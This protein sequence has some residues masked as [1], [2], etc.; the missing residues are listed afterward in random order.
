MILKFIKEYKRP[1]ICLALIILIFTGFTVRLFDWQI[2][3]GEYYREE[4]A[5]TANYRLTSDATRGE[6]V[7]KN[8]KAIETN[9]TAY[10]VTI[11]KL[12]IS[13]DLTVNQVIL[14]L[15]DVFDRMGTKWIDTL[16]II[17]DADSRFQFSSDDDAEYAL[18]TLRSEEYLDLSVYATAD[19]FMEALIERYE[20]EEYKE[21]K[22]LCRNLASVRYN[23]EMCLFS[24]TN[25]YTFAED[26]SPEITAIVSELSQSMPCIDITTV[27]KRVCVDGTL[28]PHILGIT[29]PLTAEEYDENKDKGYSYDDIIG[30]FG[31][32]SA[33]ESYL[34]GTGGTKTVSKNT[35]GTVVNVLDVEP[36]KPGNTVYLTIDYRLQEVARDSLAR[37]VKQAQENGKRTSKE[38]GGEK[39]F[40]EDC[41]AGAVVM[42]DV[43]T[44]G[45]LA[46]ATYPTY[47]LT[48]YNEGTYY[49]DLLNDEALPLYDRA[50]S[51]AFAPG[52]VVKPAVA[53]AALEE[54]TISEYTPITCTKRYDYYPSSVVNCMGYHN[55]QDVYGAIARS[56]NF[57]FADVGR[58]LGI[59]T[60]YLYMEKLGLGE[61]TGVE[62]YESSGFLAGR[63]SV[64]WLPGNTVQAAIGQ[65]DHTFTPAQLATYT[66]TIANDG[67][68]LRTHLVDKVTTYDRS[69]V[70]LQNEP[71]VVE[72]L[73]LTPY[74]LSVVQSAMRQV[75]DSSYGTAYGTFNDLGV[76]VAGKTGTAENLGSD[77]TAF[78]CYAPYEDPQVAIAVV[79]EHGVSGA[80][81][82]GVAKDL[83][84]AYFYPDRVIETAPA[85]TTAPTETTSA[86]STYPTDTHRLPWEQ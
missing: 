47:D 20:L 33:M 11:D 28:M 44:F 67:V 77:H 51:G 62:I 31:I 9:T 79:I 23:M 85:E 25:P 17:L 78:I 7:D 35:D 66:A 60:M 56:C 18:D 65:S 54:G 10:A 19:D 81:S 37:T 2:V 71:E 1:L 22:T 8:G 39:G 41:K 29:G 40:G 4:V 86:E 26:L 64:T 3:K 5:T 24:S 27:S 59:N 36:A 38:N 46:A 68:R 13:G 30:K 14:K 12:Y 50:F 42:L 32:E 53:I 70:V 45:V 21:D 76:S 57:Y 74:N 15:F 63:D 34:K 55:D 69:K 6:I 83:L 48:K 49:T 82:M 58:R 43:K 73:Q 75:V 61:H 52:S 84:T 80:Y 16:P 72:N